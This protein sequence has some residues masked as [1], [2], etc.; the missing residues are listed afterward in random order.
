MHYLA[1]LL[2]S[3]WTFQTSARIMPT[4]TLDCAAALEGGGIWCSNEG[5]F[6]DFVTNSFLHY[7]STPTVKVSSLAD[8]MPAG[9]APERF[10]SARPAC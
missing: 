2:Y 9:S 10:L 6:A 4:Q 8:K 3:Q 7:R 5:D 1:K